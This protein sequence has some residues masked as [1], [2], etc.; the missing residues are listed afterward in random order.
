MMYGI[1]GIQ[2][3][4]I[5]VQGTDVWEVNDFLDEY[6]GNIIAINPEQML[7]GVTRYIITYKAKED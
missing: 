2:I 6:D 7:Y 1:K 3:K 5:D 4:V